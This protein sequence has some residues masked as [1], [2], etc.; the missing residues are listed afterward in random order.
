VCEGDVDYLAVVDPSTFAPVPP[1][2]GA[3]VIGA[4]RFGAT[5][6]IDNIALEEAS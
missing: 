2:A 6:L 1:R 4:A 3:L 5:R